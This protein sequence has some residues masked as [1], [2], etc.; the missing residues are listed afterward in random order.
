MQEEKV[1]RTRNKASIDNLAPTKSLIDLST[2][3]NDDF[4][5][6]DYELSFLFDDILLVQYVDEGDDGTSIKRGGIYVP[7]NAATKAWRK[8]RVIMA[9]PEVKY[10]K[11]GD[12]VIFPN[13]KG[14]PV[15]NIEVAGEGRVRKGIFLNEAR[16][17]GICNETA[18]ESDKEV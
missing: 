5:I 11:K 4:G 6:E 7:I 15:A 16:L 3:V 2:H 1:I 12:I 8:A 14:I 17:F 18:C 13:D 10:C 9:G